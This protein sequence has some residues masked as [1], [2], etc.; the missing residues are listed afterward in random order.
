V[1]RR[2]IVPILVLLALAAPE[3]SRAAAPVF[4]ASA[5]WQGGGAPAEGASTTLAITVAIQE[6]W[7]VNSNVPLEDYLVPTAVRLDLPAGWTAEPAVFPPHREVRFAFSEKPLA[8]FEGM[9][10][11]TIR[12]TRAPAAALPATIGGAVEAQ[13]CNDKLCLAPTEVPFTLGTGGAV[14]TTTATPA[15]VP[16]IADSAQTPAGPEGAGG[17]S[18]AFLRGGL[19]LQ[20]AIVFLAGLALNLT[21]C[22]FPLIQIT[23]GFFLAQ[24]TSRGWLLALTYAGGMVLMY[25]ALGVA[26]ALTGS[27]F[28]AALQSVWVVGGLVLLLLVL[29]SSMFG[30]WELQVPQ[31][32]TRVSGGRQG[33][34]GALIMG[35][36]AGVVAAPCIG[37]FVLGLLTYVGQQ[38]DAVLGFALFFALALGLSLPYVVLASSTRL[39]EKLPNAGVWML[40]IRQL[41]GV[42]LVIL[43]VHFL[44]PF[45]PA[46]SG[47]MIEAALRIAGGLYLLVVARPGH[48][49][50]WVDRVMRVAS[51]AILAAG[52]LALPGGSRSDVEELAWQPY[53]EP[54]VKAAIDSGQG[55]VLDFFATW[56]VPCKELDEKTF[57][58]PR[59]AAELATYARFKIDLSR[60]DDVTEAIRSRFK[61]QG[62]PTIAFFRAG[63]EVSGA[64]LTGFEAPD[65]FL[66]RLEA[67]APR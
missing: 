2:M 50:P 32:A 7:H 40:G 60:S 64:R 37:P 56:C 54:T 28:G 46:G 45:L 55:V 47:D 21:P 63:A 11:V 66:R 10:T 44:K 24:K 67:T 65:A 23:I 57:S 17:L 52:L 62:V 31:W 43:A 5:E 33:Y 13:A 29:A 58:D 41:F 18:A 26:A 12:V 53:D 1:V 36:V 8:V 9:I 51:A 4:S 49:V 34:P 15:G 16:E 22:V 20:L 48:D 35:L 25:S 6:G 27:L 14:G 42:L 3:S 19:P 39:I 61:V 59:V 30:L 38:G